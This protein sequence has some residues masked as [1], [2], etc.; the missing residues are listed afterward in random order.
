VG[1]IQGRAVRIESEGPALEGLLHLPEGDPPFAGVVVCHPHPQMGGDMYNNVVGAL[2]KAVN[3][4]GAAALRFNFRG[5]GESEGAYDNGEGEKDDARA[6]LGALRS[7]PE[8]DAGRIA[9]AGYSF[10]AMISFR[11]AYTRDDLVAVVLVSNPTKRGT[12]VEAQ[13]PAPTLFVT[14]DRDPYCDGQLLLE[15]REQIGPDVR[16]E[17]VPGVD[18]FWWGSDGRLI[19]IVSGFLRDCL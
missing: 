14:G 17:I 7:Q 19:D 8:V 11:V 3:G 10:G 13:I 15:Y 6:A 5:V 9:L 12:K 16:V 2:V 4:A 18:H 1:V